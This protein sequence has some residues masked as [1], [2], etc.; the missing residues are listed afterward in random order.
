MEWLKALSGAVVGLD[1]APLIYLIEENSAYLPIVRPFFE[2]VDRGEF[3]VI[4]SVVTL[5]EVLVHPMREGDHDLADQY[6]RILLQAKHV[7]T[8]PVSE[9]IAE[10]AAELRARHG[11]R[12][13]DAIQLATAVSGGATSF[14]TNDTQLPSLPSLNIMVLNNLISRKR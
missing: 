14:L 12:M 7:V 4:T 10:Q 13:P 5:A 6:R 1:T 8:L 9:A 2:G 11:L 3:R